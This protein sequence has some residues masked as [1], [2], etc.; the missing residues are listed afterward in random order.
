MFIEKQLKSKLDRIKNNFRTHFE[1]S[2]LH[3]DLF[4][5]ILILNFGFFINP[6]SKKSFSKTSSH[7]ESSPLLCIA[8]Q[9]TRFCMIQMFTERYFGTD[10]SIV[11][12]VRYFGNNSIFTE[13]KQNHMCVFSMFCT[14]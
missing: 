7:L 12:Y 11:I 6:C 1:Y 5:Q 3:L 10:V 14:L 2:D 4:T 8:N 9:L 13:I